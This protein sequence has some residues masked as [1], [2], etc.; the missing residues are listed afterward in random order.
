MKDLIQ[1]PNIKGKLSNWKNDFESFIN[2]KIAT[3]DESRFVF[4]QSDLGSIFNSNI[5]ANLSDNATANKLAFYINKNLLIAADIYD[6]KIKKDEYLPDYLI[7]EF[8]VT[9]KNIE[10]FLIELE[11][12]L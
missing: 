4:D 12:E 10:K 5:K 7:D 2:G 8:G 9:C 1:F 6:L 11:S 3:I